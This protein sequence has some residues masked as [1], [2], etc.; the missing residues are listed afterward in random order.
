MQDNN[1]AHTYA[2]FEHTELH[3]LE[4]SMLLSSWVIK[5]VRKILICTLAIQIIAPYTHQLSFFSLSTWTNAQV[6]LDSLIFATIVVLA[7]SWLQ[8]K[9]DIF[10]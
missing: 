4:Q 7:Q 5:L 1:Y 3:L 9:S 8:I 10:D 2:T 6:W